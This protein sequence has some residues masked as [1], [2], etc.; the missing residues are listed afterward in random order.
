MAREYAPDEPVSK[1][2]EFAPDVAAPQ[3]NVQDDIFKEAA[4]GSLSNLESAARGTAAGIPAMVG[5]PG[6]LS[7]LGQKGVNV[8]AKKMGFQQP[9]DEKTRMPEAGPIFESTLGMIP[10]ITRTRPETKG[11]EELGSMYSPS[12]APAAGLTA[13][14]GIGAPIKAGGKVVGQAAELAEALRGVKPQPLKSKAAEQLGALTEQQTGKLAKTQQ[15]QEQLAK[16]PAIA[17]QRIQARATTPEAAGEIQR[18]VREKLG[19][20]V[21]QAQTTEQRAQKAVDQAER[22]FQ[23]SEAAVNNLEQ[24]LAGRPGITADEFG[25][26]LQNTTAKLSKDA[27][28]ARKEAAGYEKVFKE[29]GDALSVDTSGVISSIDK[30]NK[31]TRNPTLQNI[32]SEIKTQATTGAQVSSTGEFLGGKPVLSLRSTDSLKGYLDSIIS[33]KM[34]KSSPVKLDREILNTVQNLKNQLLMQANK[35]KDYKQAVDTFRKMSRPLDIVERNGSL[36]KV[37]DQDPVSTAYRMTEA[38]VAGH[39]IRKANAG[40]PVFTRLLKEQPALKE[41]A[42]LYFTK[43]LFGR[44][45]SP[46]GKAFENWL[47]NNERSLKQTGLYDEFSSLRKAQRA[48]QESVDI[49]KEQKSVTGE[50]LQT[51]AES[52]RKTEKLAE[53]G[54]AR[55][56]A[57]LKTAET[58]EQIA[59]K[60]AQSER[61]AKPSV[62]KFATQA[63]R[64]QAS[65]DA[66]S[67]LKSNVERA[68]KPEQVKTEVKATAEKLKDLGLI[69][70]QQRD[71]MLREVAQLGEDIEAKNEALKRVR[72]I[73]IGVAALGGVGWGGRHIAYGFE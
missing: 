17:E 45:A 18:G 39:V 66:L 50:R 47:I 56:G 6:S 69:N 8:A 34:H 30:L 20:K 41:S 60:V 58:P 11:M 25:R 72:N 55:L 2:R 36:R 23:A 54:T 33:S 22:E 27:V 40:N 15:V 63:E 3:K 24:K 35:N 73:V 10:R 65:L 53:K 62:Q 59:A 9:F 32:L 51:A 31:Q 16:Q 67:E 21:S 4:L 57:A 49:A 29:A 70:E 48:A 7:V 71:Q 1:K 64:Q 37:I 44:E 61:R 12:F 19:A 68:T 28:N 14:R 42:R 43:D 5:I 52:A 13:L 26:E 46:T 38:E